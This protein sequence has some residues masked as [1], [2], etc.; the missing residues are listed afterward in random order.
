[1]SNAPRNDRRTTPPNVAG[2][3]VRGLWQVDLTS[4]YFAIPSSFNFVVGVASSV[5][6]SFK[7]LILPVATD[8]VITNSIRAYDI[9][10]PVNIIGAALGSDTGNIEIVLDAPD[11]SNQI[12]VIINPFAPEWSL[13]RGLTCAGVYL[14]WQPPEPL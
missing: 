12:T 5:D 4:L 11:Y 1:M 3:K 13:H 6:D 8:I 7:P 9:N 14:R 2:G 10:G